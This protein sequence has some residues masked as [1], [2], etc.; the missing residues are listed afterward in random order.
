MP[1]N[2]ESSAEDGISLSFSWLLAGEIFQYLETEKSRNNS[3]S[4]IVFT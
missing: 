1:E 2:W 4:I 3:P